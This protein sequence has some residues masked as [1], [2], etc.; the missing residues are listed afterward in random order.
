MLDCKLSES[1]F[2]CWGLRFRDI[3]GM[4]WVW[5]MHFSACSRELRV[6][7]G[8]WAG[9]STAMVRV[10]LCGPPPIPLEQS[11]S[12]SLPYTNTPTIQNFPPISPNVSQTLDAPTQTLAAQTSLGGAFELRVGGRPFEL[13][14]FPSAGG[15]GSQLR[16]WV[17]L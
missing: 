7:G 4:C 6:S 3:L 12:V 11:L 16:R 5:A 13:S 2:S 8:G 14:A 9:N 10:E 17:A 15:F 1:G